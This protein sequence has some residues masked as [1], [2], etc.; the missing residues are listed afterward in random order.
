MLVL[1]RRLNEGVVCIANEG[2]PEEFIIE[3]EVLR[4]G[5]NIRLGFAA[6]QFVKILRKEIIKE[7][8]ETI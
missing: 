5:N 1:T 4:T 3:V 7:Q 2:T 8:K 6:P